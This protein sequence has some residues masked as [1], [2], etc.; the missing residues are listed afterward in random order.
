MFTFTYVTSRFLTVRRSVRFRN[1]VILNWLHDSKVIQ[2]VQLQL[3][4]Q[5]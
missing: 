5:E 2:K 3:R 4:S 1:M